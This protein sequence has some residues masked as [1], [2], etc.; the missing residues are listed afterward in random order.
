MDVKQCLAM[1]TG[2]T[3]GI[4]DD[5]PGSSWRKA[6]A[7]PVRPTATV[8]GLDRTTDCPW[9]DDKSSPISIL[10]ASSFSLSVSLSSLQIPPRDMS[11][12]NEPGKGEIPTPNRTTHP[13]RAHRGNPTPPRRPPSRTRYSP[14]TR[15]WDSHEYPRVPRRVRWWRASSPMGCNWGYWRKRPSGGLGRKGRM[16]RRQCTIG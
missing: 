1:R 6:D 4:R 5:P 14:P 2:K 10:R 8:D 3:V 11:S 12:R 16:R 9:C 15:C 13:P 7:P